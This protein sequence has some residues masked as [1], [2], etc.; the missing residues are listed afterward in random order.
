LGRSFR[1]P[2]SIPHRGGPGLTWSQFLRVQAQAISA[3]DLFDVDTISL[4]RLYAFFVIEHAT[5]QG[6][7]PR[8]YR[9]PHTRLAH[10]SRHATF[11]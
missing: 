3:C 4:Q 6:A 8:R 1:L 7:H 11:S 2:G 5:P 10:P 9:P